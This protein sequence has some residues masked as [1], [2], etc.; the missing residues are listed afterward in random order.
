[1]TPELSAAFDAARQVAEVISDAFEKGIDF[2]VSFEEMV[3]DGQ[4]YVFVTSERDLSNILP[5]EIS[6]TGGI[7]VK[8]E[9]TPMSKGM[10]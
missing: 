1:M 3:A 6:V 8:I 9:Q 7:K 10:Q 4:P 2:D 5:E